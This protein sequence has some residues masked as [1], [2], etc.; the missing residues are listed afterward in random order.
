MS[1]TMTPCDT[2]ADRETVKPPTP[3][4]PLEHQLRAEVRT[5]AEKVNE[6]GICVGSQDNRWVEQ[7]LTRRKARL[8]CEPCELRTDCLRMTII[9]EALSLYVY[10]GS[11]HSLH[12]ARGGLLGSARA[13]PV[14][15][16]VEAIKADAVRLKVDAARRK[17]ESGKESA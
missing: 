7:G 8:L 9:E 5:L 10:G 4:P 15:E 6:G 2:T 3:P 13:K 17:A 14:K 12:G 16:L 1:T 11:I